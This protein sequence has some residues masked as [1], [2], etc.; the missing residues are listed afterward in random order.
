MITLNPTI[1]VCGHTFVKTLLK[2]G[3][4][5]IDCGANR[6]KFSYALRERGCKVYAV[7]PVP[8]LFEALKEDEQLRKFNYCISVNKENTLYMRQKDNCATIYSGEGISDTE[9]GAKGITLNT[10][11]KQIRVESVDLLK[12]DIEG[13]E[14]DALNG[15]YD[16]ALKKIKQITV[17]FHDFVFPDLKEKAEKTK[18]NLT[19]SGFYCINF[20]L[21]NGDV[22]FVRKN[23]ISYF[24]YLYLKYVC[25]YYF[26]FKR[27]MKKYIATF[28]VR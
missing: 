13:A 1:N 28:S 20:S 11:L 3:S 16:N 10:F 17:E 2:R 7:E 21:N 25:K 18:R 12:V 26:G 8:N 24:V 9:I 15:L 23:V 14:I 4:I 19:A 5:V 27:V 22:L 6:G